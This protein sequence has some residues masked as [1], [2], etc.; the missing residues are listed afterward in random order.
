MDNDERAFKLKDIEAALRRA[1]A[2]ARR[3]AAETGTPV[4]YVRDGKIVEEYVS[5]AEARDLKKR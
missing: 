2:R 3:I 5:E 1:A 4:V